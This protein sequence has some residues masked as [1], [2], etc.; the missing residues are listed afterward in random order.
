[1]TSDSSQIHR[2]SDNFYAHP[3]EL[4][5]E[6]RLSKMPVCLH[7]SR[8]ITIFTEGSFLSTSGSIEAFKG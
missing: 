7:L 4:Y 8:V 6:E 2:M 1:M 5:V 3:I